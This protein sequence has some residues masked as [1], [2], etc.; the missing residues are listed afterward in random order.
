MELR[1]QDPVYLL[2]GLLVDPARVFGVSEAVGRRVLHGGEVVVALPLGT[3]ADLV[4][5]MFDLRL[6]SQRHLHLKGDG[7]VREPGGAVSQL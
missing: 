5:V 7:G 3:Q 2:P 4:A 1:V 6:V